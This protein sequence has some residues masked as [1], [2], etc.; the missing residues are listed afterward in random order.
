S[1]P[2]AARSRSACSTPAPPPTGCTDGRESEPAPAAARSA[3]PAPRGAG[4]AIR[5]RTRQRAG[6]RSWDERRRT[7]DEGLKTQLRRAEGERLSPLSLVLHLLSTP[8]RNPVR[9]LRGGCAGR[10]GCS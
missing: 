3:W 8:C 9:R 10:W 7:K 2:T 5:T 1:P 4:H 6:Y